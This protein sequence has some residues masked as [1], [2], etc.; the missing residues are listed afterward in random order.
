MNVLY[1]VQLATDVEDYVN[2]F[3]P[4]IME[5]VFAWAKGAKFS[6]VMKLGDVFEGSLIR[7]MKRLEEV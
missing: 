3:R 7:A 4:D 2:S 1:I 5:I 6:E